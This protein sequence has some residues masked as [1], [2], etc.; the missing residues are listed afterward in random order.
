[1]IKRQVLPLT[2]I[3]AA[4]TITQEYVETRERRMRRRLHE[5][6]E[7]DHARQFHLKR[8]AAHRAVVVGHDIH[9][10]E[11]NRL[12]RILPRPQGKRIVAQRPE[13]GIE[14]QGRKTAGRDVHVQATFLQPPLR[15]PP[16]SFVY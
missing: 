7:R 2:A 10:L 16:R 6:L 9:A 15:L 3:L 14:Y 1:M 8:G 12:D 13:I 5:G 11:E 4:K